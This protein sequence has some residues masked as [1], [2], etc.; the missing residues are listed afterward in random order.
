MME[1]KNVREMQQKLFI[2]EFYAALNTFPG[3]L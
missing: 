1:K 3:P 2:I